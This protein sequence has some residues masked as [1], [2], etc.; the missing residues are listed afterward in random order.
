M[1]NLMKSFGLALAIAA[2]AVSSALAQQYSS[3]TLSETNKLGAYTTNTAQKAVLTL[4]RNDEVNLVC[5]GALDAAGTSGITINGY[6]SSDG[7]NHDPN[8]IVTW[9]ITP[10]GTL[11]FYASTN[12][13]PSVIGAVGYIMFPDLANGNNANL[14]NFSFRAFGKPDRRQGF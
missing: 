5:T 4:T 10:R 8:I 1:K 9:T 13:P 11:P 7:V 3:A 14:T 6:P 12:I 2:L